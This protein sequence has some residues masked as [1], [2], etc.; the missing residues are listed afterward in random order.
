MDHRDRIDTLGAGVQRYLLDR[1][2]KLQ[3]DGVHARARAR[4]QVATGTALTAEPL[5]TVSNRL[6]SIM[7]RAGYQISEPMSLHFRYWFERFRSDDWA[8]DGVGP[9]QLAN[10]ILPG[11]TVD[12]YRVHVVSV[13]LRY[14]FQ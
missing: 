7:L 11:E 8:F 12:N 4:Q 9:D 6:D 3:L 2:L 14:R 13:S 5:P 1:R 10:I